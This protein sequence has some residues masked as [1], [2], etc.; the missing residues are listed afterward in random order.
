MKGLTA[1]FLKY[2][3]AVDTVMVLIFIFGFFGWK[4]TRSS[5]FPEAESRTIQVQI[6]FPGA[7]PE[8]VE[9]GVV[10]R[11]EDDVKGVTGDRT[12]QQREPGERRHHHRRSDQGL[13]YG[14]GAAGREECRGPD[15]FPC[16]MAW[17]RSVR[18][19]SRTSGLR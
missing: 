7:A 1:Y 8:E 4:A 13:R 15:S 16:P 18:S 19:S 2:S 5:L 17:S 10:L 6:I 3:V 12:D 11:I 9:E 14:P